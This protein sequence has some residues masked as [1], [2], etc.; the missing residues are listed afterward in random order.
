[1]SLKGDVYGKRT[2]DFVERLQ[3]LTD[4]VE[5]CQEIQKEL[6]WFGLHLRHGVVDAAAGATAR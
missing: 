4:Y 6:E 3:K 1:M 5:I 2:L